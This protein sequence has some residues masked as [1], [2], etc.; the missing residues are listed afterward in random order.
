MNERQQI[1]YMQARICRMASERWNETLRQVIAVFRAY[2]VLDYIEA[3]F[4]IFH[5][6]GDEAVFEDISSYL[7][8]KGAQIHA[9]S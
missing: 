4:G 8:E 5:M 1:T 3:G 2:H 7:E 6:E 9:K